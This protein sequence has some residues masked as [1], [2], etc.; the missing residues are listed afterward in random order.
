MTNHKT[1]RLWNNDI[2]QGWLSRNPEQA[3]I[4]DGTDATPVPGCQSPDFS[5]MYVYYK[6]L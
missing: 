2:S 1:R 3:S 5:Y 4:S 6:Q